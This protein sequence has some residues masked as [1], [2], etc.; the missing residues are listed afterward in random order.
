[1]IKSEKTKGTV[2]VIINHED[3][4]NEADA[5][6]KSSQK[7]FSKRSLAHFLLRSKKS[8]HSDLQFI[9]LIS[10][11]LDYLLAPLDPQVREPGQV[12]YHG[13]HLLLLHP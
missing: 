10:Y 4:I 3:C 7:E 9:L 1:M 13:L 5:N 2:V 8:I 11:P 12:Y 6:V